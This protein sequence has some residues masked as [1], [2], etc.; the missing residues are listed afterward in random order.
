M[1]MLGSGLLVRMFGDE[2]VW[3]DESPDGVDVHPGRRDVERRQKRNADGVFTMRLL[4][5][6]LERRRCAGEETP[7]ESTA[8]FQP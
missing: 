5:A 2:A 4:R 8:H 1:R 6:L 7:A 3:C